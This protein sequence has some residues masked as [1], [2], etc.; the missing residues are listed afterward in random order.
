M[1]VPKLAN[2]QRKPHEVAFVLSMD[3]NRIS[4]RM[5][6]EGLYQTANRRVNILLSHILYNCRRI[7]LCL[8]NQTIATCLVSDIGL[9][10]GRR[11]THPCERYM[12]LS[13]KHKP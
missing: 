9:L 7:L 13:T 6:G 5:R 10:Q 2:C 1:L 11:L 3:V 8:D 4:D 12:V